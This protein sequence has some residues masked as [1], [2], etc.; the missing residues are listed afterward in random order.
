M[1]PSFA[2]IV[3]SA[4]ALLGVCGSAMAQQADMSGSRS[5]AESLSSEAAVSQP[6]P[7]D[8]HASNA[9]ATFE[10]IVSPNACSLPTPWS[11]TADALFLQRTNA[12]AQSLFL[13]D[14]TVNQVFGA[15]NLNPRLGVGLRCSAVRRDLWG[16]ELELGYFE[17]DGLTA[18]ADV[19]G[20]AFLLVDSSNS[21]F[22]VSEGAAHYTSGLRLG[23]FNL[24]HR[25]CP[26]LLLLAGFRMGELNEI[27]RSTG[28]DVFSTT[29][30][31]VLL[32]EKTF[33]HLY[34][35]QIGG[36]LALYDA[37]GPFRI[38]LLAKGGI[39]GNS[40][41]LETHLSDGAVVR[42]ANG[43]HNQT[44]F[45]GDLSVRAVYDVT[46]HLSLRISGDAMWVAGV[47]LAPDQV[48][49]TNLDIGAAMVDTRDTIIYFGGSLG[50]EVKF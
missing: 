8:E 2:A 23:E 22:I 40:A 41:T 50:L 21:G 7:C 29:S 1:R 31:R 28:I 15:E 34:G 12:R 42:A 48:L 43:V 3:I 35:F 10:Q 33:N 9:N 5:L 18:N 45:L 38:D 37:G 25:F 16:C 26:G 27:Y 17:I 6:S 4:I 14:Y 47:A 13:E 19:P 30:D 24:R 11:V 39:Y 46:S 49:Q 36:D 20:Q 32:T 44:T